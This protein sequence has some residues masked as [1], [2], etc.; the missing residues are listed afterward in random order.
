M[1]DEPDHIVDPNEK[2]A[3]MSDAQLAELRE[4]VQARKDGGC[5]T[6]AI[7][8]DAA[9]DLI[10]RVRELKRAIESWLKEENFN[11][12][13]V[14][15]RDATIRELEAHI[16]EQAEKLVEQMGAFNTSANVIKDMQAQLKRH[17]KQ[18][19]SKTEEVVEVLNRL[20][21]ASKP[22]CET[23]GGE[24]GKVSGR[25]QQCNPQRC[26]CG[27]PLGLP[28]FADVKGIHN[29]TE[30]LVRKCAKCQEGE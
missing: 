25:C 7:T 27:E 4:Y 2:V 5:V 17:D 3:T 30:P 23:C 21:A 22:K 6:A 15:S 20:G 12:E 8:C 9:L 26:A 29:R 24:V 19:V 10:A 14:K 16:E 18:L 28:T 13:I 11:I 1:T